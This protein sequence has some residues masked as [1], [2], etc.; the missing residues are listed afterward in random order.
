M[1]AADDW[2][3]LQGEVVAA[4]PHRWFV[5]QMGHGPD[6]VLFHGAGGSSHSW[7]GLAGHLCGDFR[8]TAMDL[9]GQGQS[10][11]GARARLSLPNLSE[12][13]GRL[14]DTLGVRPLAVVGHSAGAALAVRLIARWQPGGDAADTA[15]RL[16]ALNGAFENFGGLAG[17]LFPVLARM[18]ALNPVAG[19]VLSQAGIGERRLRSL[20]DGTGSRLPP[21]ELDGY[22]RLVADRRHVEGTVAMMAAWSLTGLHADARH[23]LAPAL[24][25]TGSRDAA[26]PPAVSGRMARHLPRAVHE[27][28]DGLG[29]LAHEEAPRQV[30]DRIAS[31]L[32]RD[33]A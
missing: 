25:L 17:W 15:P 2:L 16:V 22:R 3:A 13:M 29:H 19:L 1:S 4:R 24:L 31:F 11:C 6:L 27:Q 20:I 23:V 10:R 26:V 14:L 30:G 18:L 28:L 8:L 7:A 5:R 12:D 33:G 32:S 21:R 9:P